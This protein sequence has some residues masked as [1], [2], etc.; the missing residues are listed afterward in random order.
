MNWGSS[1]LINDL[2]RR[3]I[4]RDA[5]DRHYVFAGRV[6]TALILVLSLIVT[7]FMN[8]VSQ[9]WQFLL[10]LGAGAGL[11]YILRWYWW[12]V[13][14]WSEVS[15]MA[16][17]LIVSVI[18]QFTVDATTPRG[19]A[20]TL[21]VTTTVTTIVWLAVTFLT[22]PEPEGKLLTF[23]EKVQPGGNGW[24]PIAEMSAIKPVRGEMVRNS[25]AWLLGVALV[26]SIMFATGALIF[27]QSEKLMMFGATAVITAVSLIAMLRGKVRTRLDLPSEAA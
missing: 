25:V 3:F 15:A 9:A 12:R 7:V 11:V 13:S 20:M 16:S 26:Y 14:A 4:R 22:K 1:F 5:P 23:Y 18:L 8:Q 10:M 17:A 6:A 19:F 21:I 2:Y 24:A 27:G